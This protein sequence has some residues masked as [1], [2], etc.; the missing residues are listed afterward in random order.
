LHTNEKS[1]SQLE[2]NTQFSDIINI[3]KKYNFDDIFLWLQVTSTHP[4]NQKYYARIDLMN[5]FLLSIPSDHFKGT[6]FLRDDC[7][8]LFNCLS[9]D[10]SSYFVPVEDYVPFDQLK[11]IPYFY[12]K[13]KYYFYYSIY[14]SP[15]EQL[16]NFHNLYLK[17]FSGD[18]VAEL[19][20]IKSSFRVSLEFQTTL[21]ETV[22]KIE[23]SKKS[24]EKVCIPSQ[25]YF[26]A[27]GSLF[28]ISQE[29]LN[30]LKNMPTLEAGDFN[31]MQ[32]KLADNPLDYNLFQSFKIKTPKERI[33]FLSPCIHIDVLYSF[34]YH[35]VKNAESKTIIEKHLQGNAQKLLQKTCQRFFTVRGGLTGLYGT[36]SHN[37]L[38]KNIDFAGVA[39]GGKILFFKLLPVHIS[40]ET[41]RQLIEATSEAQG[42]IKELKE[43]DLIGLR[44][45]DDPQKIPAIPTSI[46]EIFTIYV[47]PILTLEP[48]VLNRP[49][50][51]S[52]ENSFIV[53]LSDIQ[54]VFEHIS[55]PLAF[56]KFMR[57]DNELSKNSRILSID[58]LDRFICYIDN[59]NTFSRQGRPFNFILFQPHSWSDYYFEKLYEKN[60]DEFYELI[61]MYFPD[62]FNEIKTKGDGI[63]TLSDTS[64]LT[65]A[66]ATKFNNGLI[67]ASLPPNGYFCM[68]EEIKYSEFLCHF[69]AY[70]FNKF[71]TY[72]IEFFKRHEIRLD[73]LY[74]ISVIP[75]TYIKRQD[76]KHLIPLSDQVSEKNP[77]ETLTGRVEQTLN[78]RTAAVFDAQALPFL[79]SQKD[80]KGEKHAF[81]KL[82]I[83]LLKYLAPA[84]KTEDIES[85]IRLFIDR[86]MPI[87]PRAF[88]FDE[89]PIDNPK[90]ERYRNHEEPTGSDIARVQ[91]KIAEHIAATKIKSSEYD[92]AKAIVILES[93]FD[94]ISNIIEEEV[95]KFNQSIIYYAFEQLEFIEYE[96]V[97]LGI[98]AGIDS[99]K[100]VEYD[101]ESRFIEAYGKI[102]QAAVVVKYLCTYVA[103]LDP[104]GTKAV[105]RESW[106][107]ILALAYSAIQL[108][109]LIDM[110]RYDLRKYVIKISEMYE[111]NH[112]TKF[113]SY[114][115]QSFAQVE[116]KNKISSA[117]DRIVTN[118]KEQK[119]ETDQTVQ[120]VF[121]T[122]LD[123]VFLKEY[124]FKFMDLT[125]VLFALGR[126]D[127]KSFSPNIV[128]KCEKKS[129]MEY[130]ES[131]IT[132]DCP[133]RKV[134]NRIID[135]VSMDK[136]SFAKGKIIPTQLFREKK[137][138]NL[139]PIYHRE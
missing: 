47:I 119:K 57:D 85:D 86:I 92:G 27:V 75:I 134:I 82:L 73:N 93:S 139:C 22:C 7:E 102:S 136:K 74:I 13:R 14:E 94:F 35:L 52:D 34:A 15:Y 66:Y 51:L 21:L 133:P 54:R 43:G 105:D 100:Y 109:Y 18:N 101:V 16:E 11:L 19:Q 103:K 5:A 120:D 37:N 36:K 128:N 112:E 127:G 89:I 40:K 55:S 107:N 42:I 90:A 110:L 84:S 132:V 114:D 80:N 122:E 96:R 45:A 58:F 10:H 129:L 62:Y 8:K 12:E 72:L 113:D 99:L 70:Y 98:R 131:V 71:K 30:L 130:L 123:K 104:C 25:D 68:G 77:I 2:G 29:H 53:N 95:K 91:R 48:L 88:S 137:R 38:M 83:S 121:Y 44:Y 4:S 28:E 125:C 111:I 79:F 115:I 118:K 126:Y 97:K 106:D 56:V 6:A 81:L 138:I 23:E 20:T 124:K 26:D 49:K 65:S 24:Q 63:Y 33:L 32:S 87:G 3:L 60:K 61:E 39:D 135:F 46:A 117:K 50:D 41:D 9:K 78:L 31:Q 69:Y 76:L 1:S 67:M 17:D 108:S 59:G 64:I 116:A